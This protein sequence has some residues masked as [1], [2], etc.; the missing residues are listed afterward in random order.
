MLKKA[1]VLGASKFIGSHLIKRLVRVGFKVM[2]IVHST[3]PIWRL[4]EVMDSI[5]FKRLNMLSPKE[6]VKFIKEY[7]P[8]YIFYVSNYGEKAE[9]NNIELMYYLNLYLLKDLIEEIIED[10]FEAL[11]YI[12]SY[13]EN[14]VNEQQLNINKSNTN[15][16]VNNYGFIK[17]CASNFI[18]ETNSKLGL[19]VYSIRPNFV[20][21]SHFSEQTPFAKFL[22]NAIFKKSLIL[23]HSFLNKDFIHIK[24]LVNFILSVSILKPVN[25][26][27]FECK[28]NKILQPRELVQIMQNILPEVSI[29]NTNL[30]HYET[31]PPKYFLNNSYSHQN[32]FAWNPSIEH[33]EGLKDLVSWVQRNSLF[34]KNFFTEESLQFKI[35]SR[36]NL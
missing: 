33:K 7:S 14:E 30:A 2:A 13:L 18:K 23:D 36:I 26:A 27:S 6:V 22:L 35:N 16:Y 19:P 8:E 32:K 28:S 34:Y 11:I 3:D 5:E 25:Q 9:Q 1:L 10:K 15:S 21:G 31:E 12:S 4:T 24:D 20:Y 17:W 29:Q